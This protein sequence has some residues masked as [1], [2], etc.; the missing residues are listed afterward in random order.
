MGSDGKFYASMGGV[1]MPTSAQDIRSQEEQAYGQNTSTKDKATKHK[2]FEN[3]MSSS[4]EFD[5]VRDL[6]ASLERAQN[7][8]DRL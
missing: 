4:K 2:S 8:S 7:P 5:D 1:T 3:G 6:T